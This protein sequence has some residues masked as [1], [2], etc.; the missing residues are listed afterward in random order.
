MQQRGIH[1][2]FHASILRIHHP[3]NDQRFPLYSQIVTDTGPKHKV[4]WAA[5]KIVSHAGSKSNAIFKVLWQAEDKTWLT[6]NQVNELDLI[7]PYLDAQGVEIISK[8]PTGTGTPPIDI[9]QIFLGSCHFEDTFI[10]MPPNLKTI[11][12]H[13][14]DVSN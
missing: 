3:N 8:L 10:G 2:V 12:H 1:D 9:S 14:V 5:D 11:R 6:Y 13:L 7:P 4:K